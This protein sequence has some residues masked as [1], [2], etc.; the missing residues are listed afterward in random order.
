MKFLSKNQKRSN[1]L[2]EIFAPI[3]GLFQ[4]LLTPEK[5]D[6]SYSH[7]IIEEIFSFYCSAF[8][9]NDRVRGINYCFTNVAIPLKIF[10]K[11]KL[12]DLATIKCIIWYPKPTFQ[13][14]EKGE[15]VNFEIQSYEV[16]QDVNPLLATYKLLELRRCLGL[17]SNFILIY[18]DQVDKYSRQ[19]Y[20]RESIE[21]E[22]KEMNLLVNDLCDLRNVPDLLS[23]LRHCRQ[24]RIDPNLRKTF[25][26][27]KGGK[28]KIPKEARNGHRKVSN[29]NQ[30]YT[31]KR[32]SM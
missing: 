32:S 27:Y 24:K 30:R 22:L 11:I 26:V 2:K 5:F 9:L 16:I 3:R 15:W 8:K 29:R 18:P 21:K 17:E 25:R 28:L 10:T 13:R 20:L 7:A 1:K 23:G 31:D 6:W 14:L 12:R 4:F 19:N